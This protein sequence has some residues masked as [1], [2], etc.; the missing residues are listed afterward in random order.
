[1]IAVWPKCGENANAAFFPMTRQHSIA[2][3]DLFLLFFFLF[4]WSEWP[5][6]K[7][8]IRVLLWLMCLCLLWYVTLDRRWL[9]IA[10]CIENFSSWRTSFVLSTRGKGGRNNSAPSVADTPKKMDK[11][12]LADLLPSSFF[13]PPFLFF[14]FSW[15]I[16]LLTFS[17]FDFLGLFD[18]SG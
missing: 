9:E 4:G 18:K 3:R 16:F 5:T 8:M 1:M 2:G 7:K 12:R 10:D 17:L 13:F 14:L 11:I 6:K 15:F